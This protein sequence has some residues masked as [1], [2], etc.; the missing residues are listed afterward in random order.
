MEETEQSAVDAI[1]TS[2][3][4]KAL[5]WVFGPKTKGGSKGGR[6]GSSI[7]QGI[8]WAGSIYG[9]I[10]MFAPHFGATADHLQNFIN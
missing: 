6:W 3:W 8:T 10:Q 2:W 1:P 5:G 7:M 4:E 9:A